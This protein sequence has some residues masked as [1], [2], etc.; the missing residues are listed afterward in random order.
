MHYGC[1]FGKGGAVEESCE[2]SGS[3]ESDESEEEE[4]AY[5][6]ADDV[7]VSGHSSAR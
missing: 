5:N 7:Q 1:Y 6:S 2:R 3:A 4:G